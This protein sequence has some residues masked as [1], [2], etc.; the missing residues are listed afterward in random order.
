MNF[1]TKKIYVICETGALGD[2]IATLP[3]LK[4]LA[5]K[6]HIEKLFVDDRYTFL[7]DCI[8]PRSLL[9]PLNKAVS[10]IPKEQVT[11]EVPKH[12]IDPHTGDAAFLSYPCIAGIPIVQT[13]NPYGLMPIH[14]HLIDAFS[15][16]ICNAILKDSEK[17]YP[18]I[19]K[20][21]LPTNKCPIDNYAVVSFGSTAENRKMTPDAFEGIK[22]YLASRGLGVVLLGKSSHVLTI[23]A[24]GEVVG[25][26]FDGLDD[27]GCCNMIDK[28]TIAE[29]LSILHDAKCFI[30][31]D[32][33]LMHLAGMTDIPIVGGF[34][35][36][37][38]YY[39]IIY[40]HGERGWKFYPVEPTTECRYCQTEAWCAFGVNF[41]V[42]HAKTHDCMRSLTADVWTAQIARALDAV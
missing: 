32:G 7:Y 37:D 19:E 2:T 3:T 41:H 38:P 16:A 13:M 33:G 26:K 40:R 12:V 29:S 35:S 22:A 15:A 5:D 17:D 31:I 6:G 14:A 9:Y 1:E 24:T 8:F 21:K 36:V 30:G 20:K 23:G 28:T 34:T 39:R 18:F 11:A 42:C 4:I 10:R 27:T 25:T